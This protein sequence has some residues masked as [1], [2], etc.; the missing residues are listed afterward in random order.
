MKNVVIVGAQWGDEGKGKVVDFLTPLSDI[1]ARFQGGN[2]AGHTIVVKGEKIILHLV[3]S[4]ILYSRKRCVIG[5]GVVVDPKVLCGELD[6]LIGR[7]YFKNDRQLLISERAHLI[8]PYHKQIDLAREAR[9]GKKRM[10]GT[11]GR[12][13]GPAYEDKAARTGIRFLDLLDAKTF[14]DKLKLRLRDKNAYL[15]KILGEKRMRLKPI[16]DEYLE[17]GER[18]KRYVTD[19]SL[20]LSRQAG[21][22]KRIL[23]EG[24]QGV[25]LDIDHGTYPYVTSSNTCTGGVCSGSGI[26]PNLIN[27]VIGI[28]KAYTTRVGAGPF[29]TELF[30][31]TG[32]WIRDQ[33]A[34]YGSTTGRP[35]RCGW[36]DAVVVRYATRVNGLSSLV[37]T[38]L[39]VLSGLK[40]VRIC[41]GYRYKGKLLKEFPADLG[42]LAACKPVYQ[43]MPGWDEDIKGVTNLE[44]LPVKARRYIDRI[45]RLTGVP[46]ELISTGQSRD[47]MIVVTDPYGG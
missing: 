31:A 5:N 12:G 17:Y 37:L 3:P 2:N 43:D 15:D 26:G 39:D 1:I 45:E 41:N 11:T 18:L 8:L 25:H 9:R 38:K 10:I 22:G 42:I 40:K 35:R 44:D 4:G 23:F 28:A 21:Q 30:D 19:T 16:L 13:I 34:E 27:R 29:P 20:F 24:A 6:G 7:G 32:K 46:C 36:Y 14:H 47:E 33:G